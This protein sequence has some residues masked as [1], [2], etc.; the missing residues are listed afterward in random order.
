MHNNLPMNKSKNF[1]TAHANTRWKYSQKKRF[2]SFVNSSTELNSRRKRRERME[3]SCLHRI[4]FA[5]CFARMVFWHCLHIN[6]V[7]GRIGKGNFSS[8]WFVCILIILCVRVRVCFFSSFFLC[9]RCAHC[10]ALFVNIGFSTY[11]PGW[12]TERNMFL[13]SKKVSI[14][15]YSILSF[16]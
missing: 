14:N 5:C 12:A 10:S 3:E 4:L 11:I 9:V 8:I 7:C 16:S 1:I 15:T 2:K 6:A 13:Y